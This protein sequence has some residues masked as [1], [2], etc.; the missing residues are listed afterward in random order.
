MPHREGA[1]A[2]S[3]LSPFDRDE[4]HAAHPRDADR[5]VRFVRAALFALC[6]L[7]G[8]AA[9]WTGVV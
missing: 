9:F 7:C 1:D 3:H 6:I 8:V 2:V 5:R 4:Y